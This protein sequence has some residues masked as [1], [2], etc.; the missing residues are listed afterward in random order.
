M[1]TKRKVRDAYSEHIGRK[2]ENTEKELVNNLVYKYL[3]QLNQVG[4]SSQYSSSLTCDSCN[5]L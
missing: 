2:L 5:E 1:L 3:D 4:H